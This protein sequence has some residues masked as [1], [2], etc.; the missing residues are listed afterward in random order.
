VSSTAFH[1][2]PS[3]ATVKKA[4]CSDFDFIMIQHEVGQ[5]RA[6]KPDLVLNH[7]EVGKRSGQRW[8]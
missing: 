6:E 3:P 1:L 2:L 5:L 7:D 8:F 4:T